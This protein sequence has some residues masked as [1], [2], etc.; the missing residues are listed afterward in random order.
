MNF[1]YSILYYCKYSALYVLDLAHFNT[2]DLS[3]AV[4]GLH[5]DPDISV[6]HRLFAVFHTKEINSR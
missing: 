5:P 3:T 6:A 2:S 1:R 4:A